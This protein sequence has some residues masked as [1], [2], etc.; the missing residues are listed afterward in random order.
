MIIATRGCHS[1]SCP[2]SILPVECP[3]NHHP[4]NLTRS[5]TNLI[6]FRIPQ[7]SPRRNLVDVAIAAHELDRVQRTLGGPLRSVQDRARAVLRADHGAGFGHAR[8]VDLLGGGICVRP[9]GAELGVHVGQL[10]L[11]ELVVGD[12]SAE[13]F[14]GVRVREDEVQRGLHD[15]VARFQSAFWSVAWV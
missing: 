10:A 12:G 11:D 7:Q 6:E 15:S 8:L 14:P 5:G 13:L 9:G 3:P 2:R 4:A 1:P